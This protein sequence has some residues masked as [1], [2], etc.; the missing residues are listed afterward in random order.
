MKTFDSGLF[1]TKPFHVGR[2]GEMGVHLLPLLK[3]IKEFPAKIR[4]L[5]ES[6]GVS[7]S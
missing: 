6:S 5:L 1:F 7:L 4:P 2:V 3:S